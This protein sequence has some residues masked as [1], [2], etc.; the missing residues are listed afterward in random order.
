MA[1][2]YVTQL[3]IID[4]TCLSSSSNSFMVGIISGR[5]PEA[6]IICIGPAANGNK[7][8]A[9][10]IQPGYTNLAHIYVTGSKTNIKLVNTR[11]EGS[12]IF[13]E[14]KPL[15]I[16]DDSIHRN[17]IIGTIGHTGVKADLNRNPGIDLM[18]SK[19]VGLDPVPY[20]QLWNAAFKGYND[21][22]NSMPGW[23]VPGLGDGGITVLDTS[24]QFCADHN[25]IAI[26]HLDPVTTSNPG[27]SA[28]KL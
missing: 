17:L 25:V 3:H 1:I 19:M 26:H 27:G 4:C 15:V 11:M 14:Q 7:F 16:I 13:A 10:S 9:M 22:T 18:I 2:L 20:N 23:D 5:V 24:E 21:D 8:I 12:D 6:E 28:I